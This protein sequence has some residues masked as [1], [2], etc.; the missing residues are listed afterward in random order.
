MIRTIII[1]DEPSAVNVLRL[2]LQ[3]KCSEDVEII[4]TACAP[5]E[6]KKM[7]DEHKPDLV[8]LDIEMPGMTGIDLLRSIA[9]PNLRVIFVTAF[10][11][12]AV[13]AFRLGVIDY[14]LKPV[15]ADDVIRAV[16]KIKNDIQRNEN[17]IS[18]Q[19]LQLEKL[20]LQ[21]KIGGEPRIGIGMTDKI[22]FVNIA[23]I[24]YC[25]ATGSYATVYLQNG[26]KMLASKL[27][28]EFESQ[29]K[30][31]RFYRIH[32]SFLINLNRVK[33]F[34]RY[35]GGYVVMQNNKQL[36]VSQRKRK[37]FLKVIYGRN[38]QH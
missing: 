23:D 22:V 1:D 10:D 16:N 32:H 17:P 25:E 37:D 18:A 38:T 24:L 9:D 33:E 4:A 20:L 21:N 7:I 2:L 26:E 31:Y 3:K 15:E 11:A 27:L 36:E 13:E 19:L 6:G 12:Y 29:L 34:Q 28:G 30:D 35:D 14:L 5:M 8:F